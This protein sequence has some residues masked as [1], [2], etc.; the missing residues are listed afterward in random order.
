M[1]CP[2]NENDMNVPEYQKDQVKFINDGWEITGGTRVSTKTS[3]NLLGGFIEFDMNTRRANGGVNNNIYTISPDRDMVGSTTYC[4]IQGDPKKDKFCMELD[5]LENNGNCGYSS[6][7]HTTIGW[8]HHHCDQGGCANVGYLPQDGETFHV[9]STY[10]EDGFW[11]V[12]MNGKP[13]HPNNYEANVLSKWDYDFVKKNMNDVGAAIVSSQWEGWVPWDPS[14]EKDSKCQTS[15]D[16]LPNA[17]QLLDSSVFAISN[18]KVY[19][20]VSHG[21]EPTKCP[22][23]EK[24]SEKYVDEK[25]APR[26]PATP[27]SPSATMMVWLGLPSFLGLILVGRW[28]RRSQSYYASSATEV[29]LEEGAE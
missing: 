3:F 22:P 28:L 5:I 9:K 20:K 18:L 24:S 27:A 11:L 14:Q 10:R 4:D 2:A 23:S 12:T 26:Q 15:A 17:K 7:W 29:V 8:D 1:Y 19:G 16:K 25:T 13:L 6:T 21:P